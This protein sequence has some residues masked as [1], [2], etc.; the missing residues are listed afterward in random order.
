VELVSQ[1]SEAEIAQN[2]AREGLRWP[3]RRL[4]AA[5]IR[6]VRGAGDPQDILRHVNALIDALLAYETAFGHSPTGHEVRE[7]LA[8]DRNLSRLGDFGEAQE[9]IVSG[10][11]RLVAGRLIRQDLQARHGENELMGGFYRLEEIREGYRRKLRSE[12]TTSRS[13][14]KRPPKRPPIEL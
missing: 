2:F 9:T 10:A 1:N 13:Q 8:D 12:R 11:L 6:I 7:A 3:L 4:T 5:L 14:T